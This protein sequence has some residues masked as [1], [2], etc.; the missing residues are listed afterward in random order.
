VFDFITRSAIPLLEAQR[1]NT[2]FA[3]IRAYRALL[4]R[5]FKIARAWFSACAYFNDLFVIRLHGRRAIN[6]LEL[7][8]LYAFTRFHISK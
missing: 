7:R 8:L 6:L 5:T 4:A 1:E 3:L 2:S